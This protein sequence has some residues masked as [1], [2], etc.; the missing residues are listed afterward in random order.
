MTRRRA[1]PAIRATSISVMSATLSCAP[2]AP[3]SRSK[4]SCAG[5]EAMRCGPALPAGGILLGYYRWPHRRRLP[6]GSRRRGIRA[7][8]D[9][10]VEDVV[11]LHQLGAVELRTTDLLQ[12][13]YQRRATADAGALLCTPS[14]QLAVMDALGQVGYDMGLTGAPLGPTARDKKIF[15]K[16]S[17]ALSGSVGALASS[18]SVSFLRCSISCSRCVGGG[19]AY[20]GG[21]SRG[22][23]GGGGGGG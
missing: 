10:T 3:L 20:G 23:G 6:S 1:D 12:D 4:N 17:Q 14:R 2:P 8:A 22:G 19:G 7:P 5:A 16:A 18:A 15:S 13:N 9:D 21:G 11:R